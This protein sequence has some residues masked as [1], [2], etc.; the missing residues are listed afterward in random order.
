MSEKG[1][2]EQSPWNHTN[3]VQEEFC[4]S[5]TQFSSIQE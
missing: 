4:V 1:V 2:R 3:N 5:L